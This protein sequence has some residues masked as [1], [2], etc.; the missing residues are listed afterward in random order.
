MLVFI[1]VLFVL[2]Q[3]PEPDLEAEN[4]QLHRKNQALRHALHQTLSMEAKA[5][6]SET[7]ASGKAELIRRL[8]AWGF[9]LGAIIVE[10]AAT[11]CLKKSNGSFFNWFFAA[12]LLCWNMCFLLVNPVY[13]VLDMSVGYAVWCGAGIVLTAVF[14]ILFFNERNSQLK[15]GSLVVILLG[16]SGFQYD[17][18]QNAQN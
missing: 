7:E 5:L 9:L 17:E 16:I 18:F 8:K 13:Q 3:A 14:G 1:L 10:V 2:S 6:S 4:L 12:A 15:T 11:C